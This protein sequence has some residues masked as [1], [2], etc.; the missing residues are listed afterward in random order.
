VQHV[1][2]SLPPAAPHCC[3]LVQVPEHVNTVPLQGSVHVPPQRF[4]GQP[5]AGVQHVAWS[6]AE[7]TCPGLVQFVV[8]LI[9]V[10]VHGSLKEPQ[11]PAGHVFGV[12]HWF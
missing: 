2:W 10:F 8:Q 9:V 1:F 11:N 6:V 5:V 7:H 12:Q 3:G 4:A